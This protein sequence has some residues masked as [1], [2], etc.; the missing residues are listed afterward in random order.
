LLELEKEV[1]G[2]TDLD[3]LEIYVGEKSK[4]YLGKWG[5]VGVDDVKLDNK[6]KSF[7]SWNWSAFLVGLFWMGY[8]KMYLE[9]MYLLLI[10]LVCDF[11]TY[12]LEFDVNWGVNIATGV[13]IGLFGNAFYLSRAKKEIIRLK[14]LGLSE[15]VEKLELS[16]KGGTSVGGIFI[17]LAMGIGY[18]II[19]SILFGF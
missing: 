17:A 18:G 14:Q 13:T 12:V 4:K 15:E 1:V 16:K 5:I 11:I 10:F 19:S 3:R 2:L 6:V 7:S 8:R 9:L